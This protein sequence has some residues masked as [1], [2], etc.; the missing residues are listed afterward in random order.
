MLTGSSACYDVYQ[1]AD[2]K[3]LAVA[4]IEPHFWAA[5]C[6]GLG[7]PHRIPDQHNPS[8]QDVLRDELRRAFATR[9]SG[10]WLRLLGPVACVSPVNS[11]AETLR[12]PHLRAR[13]LTVDVRVGE[14]TVRQMAPRLAVDDPADLAKQPAGPTSAA[15]VNATLQQMGIPGGEIAGL[16]RAAVITE[17]PEWR[18]PCS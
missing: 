18:P 11:P 16:R 2:G 17:A 5:L 6:T 10:E 7:L 9:A 8:L 14:H 3:W 15:E 12:D 1:A 4:A 13:P